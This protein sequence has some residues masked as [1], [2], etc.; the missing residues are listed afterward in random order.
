MM[1][2]SSFL[3]QM[4][5]GSSLKTTISREDLPGSAHWFWGWN[6]VCFTSFEN[7]LRLESRNCVNSLLS[8]FFFQAFPMKN[9]SMVVAGGGERISF[10]MF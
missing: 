9:G 5:R 2:E 4:R 6:A 7:R 3:T 8:P 10:L 1:V